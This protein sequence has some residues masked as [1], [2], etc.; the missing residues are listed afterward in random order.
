[1]T[2][3]FSELEYIR[4]LNDMINGRLLHLAELKSKAYPSAITYD[5]SGASKPMPVN[6]LELVYELI[7]EEERLINRLIDKRIRLKRKAVYEIQHSGMSQA[8]RHILYLRYLSRNM[9]TGENLEL[10]ECRKYIAKYHNITDRH[11]YR[12]QHIALMKLG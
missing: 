7:D 2:M 10:S 5:D 1:M 4:Y 12:L 3:T 9:N 6:K 8:E 11:I